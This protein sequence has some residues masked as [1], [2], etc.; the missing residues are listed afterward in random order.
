MHIG[1]NNN[2]VMYSLHYFLPFLLTSVLLSVS[3]G[4]K[5][6]PAFDIYVSDAAGFNTGPYQ[7]LRFNQEGTE[8][9][10]FISEDLAWPQDIVFL[11]H[12]NTVLISNLTSGRIT[13]HDIS[14]GNRIDNFATGIGGPTRMK[15]RK[16]TLYVL[17][18][19]GNGTV[20]RYTLDGTQL[21]PYTTV[22]VSNSIGMDW[23]SDGNFYVSSFAPTP[24]I[25]KFDSSG[26][27]LGIVVNSNLVGPTNITFY[28]RG[29]DQLLVLDY[30]GGRIQKF[31]TEG[32]FQ[33]T[34]ASGLQNPEG[35]DVLPDGNI[36]VGNG[37]TGT[38]LIYDPDGNFVNEI[39]PIA[40][41]QLSTPNAVILRDTRTTS[42]LNILDDPIPVLFP[43][44]GRHFNIPVNIETVDIYDA[45]GQS[46]GRIENQKSWDANYV[47]Q[48]TYFAQ[49]ITKN[50]HRYHQKLLI[51]P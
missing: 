2:D 33:G 29:G 49:I 23:D 38:L 6:E 1:P 3:Y 36:I 18:W 10:Q 25:R 5:E 19:T 24:L 16:D 50:G 34:F 15:I 41:V 22:G 27:D 4:Q 39:R 51:H 44:M 7:I 30:S 42:T 47:P 9:T 46:I 21:P 26:Q 31:D 11:E 13:K 48:G 17:Q 40:P 35:F 32:R 8:V 43:N 45:L 12:E 37:G 20:F 28:P 14:T